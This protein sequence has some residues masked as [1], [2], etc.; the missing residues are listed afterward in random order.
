M[1]D[2][3]CVEIIE[4]DKRDG[5]SLMVLEKNRYFKFF[6]IKHFYLYYFITSSSTLFATFII[7]F[8]VDMLFDH[9]SKQHKSEV[10]NKRR[11]LL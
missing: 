8:W 3:E 5:F 6:Y 7:T 11:K 10:E 2:T 9:S 4:T 1:T